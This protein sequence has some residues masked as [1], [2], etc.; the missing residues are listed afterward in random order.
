MGIYFCGLTN[1]PAA[2][3]KRKI[4]KS[5]FCKYHT[6]LFWILLCTACATTGEPKSS[7]FIR[8]GREQ[9]SLQNCRGK[10]SDN[11]RTQLF[12]NPFLERYKMLQ[13]PNKCCIENKVNDF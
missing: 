1:F 8:A 6:F 4:P 9:L 10:N 7:D 11:L 12:P 13:L 3:N 2:G 5:K